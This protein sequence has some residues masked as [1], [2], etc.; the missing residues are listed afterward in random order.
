MLLRLD[1]S[2]TMSKKEKL[3]DEIELVLLRTTSDNFEFNLITGLLEEADIAFIIK[4]RG[5]G[6]YMKIIAGNSLYGTDIY[7]EESTFE[8]AEDILSSFEWSKKD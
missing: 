4:E 7:V 2:D 5:S 8:R 6:G 1:G 3:E